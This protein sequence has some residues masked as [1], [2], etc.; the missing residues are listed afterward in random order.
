MNRPENS[1]VPPVKAL[2]FDVFG[3]MVDWRTS[4]ARESKVILS[5]LG[6]SLDWLAFADAW[7]GEY[8]PRLEEVRS[9]REPYTKLDA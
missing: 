6:H 8:Q 5:P 2:F 3:S 4:I 1:L 9:G 7:R